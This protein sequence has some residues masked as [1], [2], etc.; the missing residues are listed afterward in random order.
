MATPI[1]QDRLAIGF[2]F[3]EADIGSSLDPPGEIELQTW[4]D[5][6]NWR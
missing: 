3:S 2:S 1:S 6:I 4:E 5:W